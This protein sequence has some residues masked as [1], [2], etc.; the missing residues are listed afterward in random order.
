MHAE[1]LQVTDRGHQLAK[2]W[3]QLSESYCTTLFEYN[4]SLFLS[5]TFIISLY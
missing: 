3:K 4:Y 1:Y 2:L 5:V